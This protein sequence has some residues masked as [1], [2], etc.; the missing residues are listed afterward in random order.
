MPVR[1]ANA[2]A[3]ANANPIDDPDEVLRVALELHARD[4]HTRDSEAQRAALRETLDVLG[5]EP[6]LLARA[7]VELARREQ[8]HLEARTRRRWLGIQIGLVVGALACSALVA[9]TALRSPDPWRD[10]VIDRSRWSLVKNADSSGT[11]TWTRDG[12]RE[13]ATVFVDL[14]KPD[15]HDSWRVDLNGTDL[16]DFDGHDTIRIELQSSLPRARLVLRAGPDERWVSPAIELGEGWHTHALTLRSFE[17]QR[18]ERRGWS[19][20]DRSDRRPPAEIDTLTVTL[21][22]PINPVHASGW[23]RIRSVVVD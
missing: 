6:D 23:L 11:L 12:A 8:A 13:S 21:G 16:P 15:T 17:H 19:R 22:D 1:P 3:N 10:D 14:L 20:V 7:E 5:A 2:N 18:L 9:W 4:E